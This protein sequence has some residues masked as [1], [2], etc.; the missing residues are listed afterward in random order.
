MKMDQSKMCRFSSILLVIAVILPAALSQSLP[1]VTVVSTTYQA[2]TGGSVTLQCTA[3]GNPGVTVIT[4]LKTVNSVESTITIDGSKYQQGTT[5]NPSLV[6]TSLATSDTATYVCRAT[7]SI[8][9]TDSQDIQL[10]VTGAPTVIIGQSAY[11]VNT[12]V[13]SVTLVCTVNNNGAALTGVS[14]TRNGATLTIDGTKYQNA[15]TGTP[16]LTITSPTNADDGTYVCS[17]SNSQGTTSSTPTTLTV[18]SNPPDVTIAQTAFGAQVSTTITL[19]CTVNSDTTVI[20]VFWQRDIGSGTETITV[21]GINFSGSTPTVPSLT[22]INADTTDSGSYQCF[23]T[24]AAG[25]SSSAIASVTIVSA[26]PTVTVAQSAYSI[27]TGTSVTLTCTV[28]SA[29]TVTSVFWQRTIGGNTVTLTIDNVN[30]SGSSPSTPSLTVIAADSGDVGSYTCFAVNNAGTGNSAAT[31][32]SVTGNAPTVTVGSSSYSTTTGTTFTLQCTVTSSLTI[33]NVFWQRTINGVTNS[34]T[35]DNVNYSGATTSSPSLTIISA[36]SGDT[37]TY[38]CFG[39]NTAGT[40]SATTQLT[41]TGAAPTVTV[42]STSYST[43]TGTTFTLQCTVTSSLT[44]NNVFWQRTFNGVTTTLTI[45]NVNY[46]GATTSSPSLTII[47]ADSGDTGTYTCFGSNAAGTSSATTQLTVTGTAPTVTVGSTAYSTTTGT[48]FTLQC[49]VTSSLTITNVFWQ[50]TINGV[51][52]TLTIDNV[53]YSG[54]STSSPSLTIISVDPT[55]TG[56]YTCFG[57]NAAGTSSATTQLTVTG[58]IPVVSVGQA[59]YSVTTGTTITLACTVSADPTHTTVFWRRDVGSGTESLTIDN[60]NYSGSQVNTPSL[61][62]I[63]TEI[64]DSGT[65]TCFATNAVGTGQSSTTLTVSGTIPTATINEATAT[66]LIASTIV[67]SCTVSGNPAVSSVFWQKTANS[68]TENVNIDDVKFSGSTT[69]F[70]SLIIFNAASSDSGDYQCFAVNDVG[71]GQSSTITLTVTGTVPT[72]TVTQSFYTATTGTSITLGCTVSNAN[73]AH[74]NVFWQRNVGTG[75]Q[76]ITIDN[77]NYSG[78]QVG[79]PSLTVINVDPTDSGTYSCFATN[80]VGTSTGS[81]TTLTVTGNLPVVT[82]AQTVYSVTTGTTVTLQCSVSANPTHTSVFWQFTP[83]NGGTTTLT[84]D[85]VNYAGS[86]VSSPSLVVFN[87]NSGDQGTYTCFATNQVGTGQSAQVSLSVTGSLPVV[88]VAQNAYSVT[89][90]QSITLGC[91]VSATPTHTNVFWQRIDNGVASTLNIDGVKYTGSTVNGPSLTINSASSNDATVYTCSATNAVGTGTSGQT[92]LSVTGNLPVVTV[93]Q[94]VYSVA[95]GQSVTLQCSVSANPTHTSVFWQFTPTNGGTTTLTIDNVNYA[96]SSVSSPSLVVFNANSGDQ[97]TY[98]C[99]ATNQVGTGQSAQVSLS[100]TGSLPVVLVDQAQYSVITG[101]TVTLGCTVTAT[102]GHTSVLWRRSLNGVETLITI[103]GTKYQ[104]ATVANPDLTITNAAAGDG[105]QYLCT[106]TNVVGTGTST[107]T[108]LIV[109]GNIPVVTVSQTVYSVTTGQAVT[110]QCSVSANPTHTSVF[111]QFT[112]TNGGTTT[113]TIDNVNYAGSSVSSPSLVVFNTNSGDQGTYTCFATNQVGTGQSAQVSLSVTGSLPVVTI[114]QNAYSVT[115]GQ[116]ITLGCTVSA[117]PTHTNVFW[118]RIDNGVS[119]T[120]TIDGSKYTGSTV[121]GPS[122]TINSASSNDA[123]VYTC[124]ATN[125]VGTGTSGQTS[126]SVTGNIPVVTVSQTVYSVTTGTT[127]TLQCSVSANPTHT[128]VFWQFTPTNGGTTTLTIDNVNYAGSSVSS[129]SLV[130]FNTNSGDQGTYTCFATNQV[131]T[132]QSAQV[133]LSVT[134][135]IPVVTV[136]QAQYSVITGQTVTLGCTVTATPGHTNVFWQRTLNGV[137]NT[138]TIDGNKYQGVTVANPDLTI[139]NAVAGDQAVYSCSATNIVGTGTSTTTTLTVTGNLPIVTIAQNTYSVTTGQS[140]TLGCTVSATPT[141]TNVFWQRIDNGV[142]TTLN[143]DGIKYSGSTVN[144]P[145]LTI[146]SANSNDAT[147][148]TCSATNAVGTGTSGQTTLSVTGNLPIVT[149]SQNTYSVTTGQSITLVCTVSATPTHTNVFWQRIDNGVATTLN[150]DGVKYSGSTVNGPSLTI[151]SANSN[152]ATVYTCSATNAVGTGTSGQTT[153]TVTGSIPVVTVDQAQNS[154]ITGQTVTLGCTVTATPGHTTVFWQRTLNG[155]TNSITI[156]GTKYQGATVAN[157]DLTITN[158]VAGDQAVY[159]CSATNIVGT[160]TSTTTTLTVTGSIPV[161]TVDQAQYSVITGQTVTLGCTVAATPGHTSVFW[162]RTLNGNTNTLTIDGT[163]YQGATLANPDLIITNAV[164]GDQAVYTC[165]ATNIVGTGTSTTTTLTVTGSLPIV[166]IAQNAYSVTTGQSITLG[167]TVSATPTHTNVFWQR[168]DNGVATTLT[169]D[170]TKYTGS[171]VNG[172]SLTIN[173]ASSNDATVYTCSAT[174]TVGTGTSGQTTLTVTGSIPVVTV[175]QAQY[176]VITG[177]TVTLG[178]TVAATPGH[179]SVFWQRTLNGNTNTLTIDGTK[180]QGATVANPDLII[181]NAVAGDQAVYTCSAT[182]IVGTG[183]STTTTLTVTGSLPIVTIAQNTYSVTTGQSITLG[184]TVSATP[185]H[186][187]VFW[188]RIDN[189]VATTLNIDGVKYSGS[190]VNGP[191]LTI[192]SANSNDATVYTCSATN[193]VGTGTSGQTTLTVTGSLPIVTI[194][195]NAYSV[196]TGQSITLGCTVS[197]TPTHTN[198]FWQRIDNGV[199]TTLTIDGSKYTGSTVNGPSLTIN[200]ASSNDATVYTCSATNAVGTGTSGQTALSV[201][202]SIPVVTVDQAQYSVITGQTVTLGCTVTATP[203]HNSVFWQRTLNGVTSTLTIDGNKYQ[204]ATVANPDL[205]I[206]NAVAGDQAVYTCSATNIVGT[207]TSTTTTLTVTGSLPI[208]TIAQNAYSVTTGQSITLVCTVSATPTH[209]NV[210]WQRIDNGVA[211]T[212][213]IDGVKYSGS[214]VNGPS[215][216][217]N[218]ASSNDATVYT[219]SA[220]NA[221][222]TGTS[223]QTTLT[224]TGSIPVVTVDQAQYSVITGQ[225]VTLGCTVTATPGHTSVFWQRTLNGVTNTLTIDGAKY[226]GATVA[227]P[228]LI[229]TNAVAGDQAVYTCSATNI[230]GT[231]TSTTTTLTVT[232]SLPIVTIAQNAYS[233]TTGQSIT[234]VCTVSATPTHTNVFWQR[235][236]NGVATT[237]TIDGSK[238]TGSTVNGPSLTINSASSNDAT[239]YTCSATNAVGTGTSGQTTLTVTGSIP[240]VT[241]DQAQYSVITGQTVTLGCTVAATPGHTTVFWQRTLNGVTST[242]NIDG[243]KYQGATVANPDLTITNSV[244]NDQAVYTCSATNIVGTGTSTTTTLTVTGSL[245]IVTI[246]QNAYSVTTGQSITLGCTVS[247]TPTHTN[248][249][250]QRIDNGVATTLTIDGSKYTGSTVNGPSLTINSANSNDATVYTCSATNAVGTGTSGQTALSVTGSIPVVTVDQAQYSVITGQTVTLGCTVAATP[251][252]TSAF[253][254]RTLNG[255][256]STLTIDGNKYQGSTVANPDLTITNAVASDLAVYTC[257]ATNIVGTGTSTTTTLTVTGSIPVVTVDQAQ[258]SVITGQTVTLG[259]TVTATPVHTSVFWRKTLNGVTSSVTVDGNKYQGATVANPDLII[260]NAVA[261]DQAVYTCSATN[262]VGTGTSTTTTLTVTGSLPIVTIAQNTYSVTTGQSITL[263][264]TVSATPTHTNVFWQRIDN[265]VATTLTIDGSKYT[266]STVNGPSLTINSAS[267]N[268]ATVYTCSATNAVGTGTSGQTTLSV[269]GNVPVVTVDQA[270]YSVIT[271]QTVTLGCTVTATPGHTSVLWR[272]LLNG[273]TSN[274]VI[275]NSKYQGATVANPDLTITNAVAGDQAVYT[276]SATNIVGT[277]TS[278]TTTLTVTGNLPIVTI[279]Q[280]TYSVT[281]G[282]S[283]TLGCSV[284]ATPTHTNVFWQRIDNGVATTLTIDGSKYTGSTVNGPSLTIN[285]ANSNDATVYTCSATNAVGTGTSGQTTLAVTGSIPVVTVDQAQYSVITGQTVTLGCTVTAT[286]GH[287]SVFWQRT[288]N[289]VTS[290]LSIDGTKYQ[291][292]TVANPDLTIT[293]AVAGDQAVYTCSATNIVGTG[294][295]TTTTLTVTGSLPI[296]TVAQNAYSVVTGQTI[297]LGCTVSATPTHTNVFWQRIDNGVATTLTI[298]GTKY[299]GSTVNNP[300]LT[301]F[302]SAANDATVYT[303]SATNAVGTGTSGQT[304]LAVTGSIPVVTIAQPAYSVITG[305]TVVLQCIVSADPTH[306]QVFWQRTVNGNT[307]NVAIDGNK[308]QGSVPNT[309]SLTITN[310]ASS[311]QATYTCSATNAVGTGT[312]TS[313]TLTVTGSIPVVTVAQSS[314]SV[315]TGSTATLECTVSADPTHTTVFWQRIVNGVSTNIVID[316]NN[317]AG[318]SV[319]SPSLQV[320]NANSGDEG[321]YICFATNIV[322]T[323]QSAQTTLTVTGNLPVVVIAQNAYSVITGQSITLG[324][325]VTATPSHTNVY[326]QRIDNGVASTL[327]IDGTKYTGSTVNGPSLTI[328]NAENNDQTTY[329]CSAT[330]AVGT[331]T[332]GQTTL[333]VTGNVPVVN[334]MQNQYNV[335]TGTTATLECVVSADPAHFSVYWQ[336]VQNGITE[337]IQIDGVNYGGSTVSDPS[338]VVFNANTADQGV[339]ICFATNIVGTGQSAQ[340]VLSV[341]GSLPVVVIAQNAYSVTTGQSITLGCTVT[342]T[343][344][345]TNVYWQRIDNGVASTLTIDGSKYT[346]STVNGPSLTINNA[347][348][349]DQ[350]TYTC[351]ATNAVGTGTSGQTTLTVTG[352]PPVPTI[353]QNAYSV[354]TGQ[355]ITLECTVQSDPAHTTVFWQRFVNGQAQSITIDGTKYLGATVNSASLVINNAVSADQGVYI[356]FAT[357]IV[358]TGQSGQTVLSVTGS[359]PVVTI[360]QPSYSAITGQ[361]VTLECTVSANPTHSQVFW[362]RIDNGVATTINLNN[363]NKYSGSTVNSPSLTIL[364]VASNDQALYTCSATNVVGTGTS[365]QTTLTVTGSIPVVTIQQPTYSV[366]TGQSVTLTCVVT[367]TPQ[368]TTVFWQRVVNGQS[369]SITIDNSKYSG[370]TVSSPSITISNAEAA[371][372]G[373]YI[374]FATNIV[375]TGQSSQ[376]TLT[377][378]GT[379][380][381]VTIAQASYSVIT[382]QSITLGCTVSADPLHTQVYWQRVINGVSNV[383]TIDGNKYAGSTVNSPDLVIFNAASGDIATYT[384]S[385]VNAV[386]TGTSAT[387]TLTVT[388]SPPTVTI[389]QQSYTITIGTTVTIECTVSS[390]PTHTSVFWQRVI[391]GQTESI[392]IDGTNFGGSTVGSASLI[393]FNADQ[394]DEGTYICFATNVVGTGQSSPTALVVTGSIPVVTVQQTQ[395]SIVTGNDVT[396]QCT[397]TADPAHTSV[398]WERTIGGVTTQL[399]IDNVNYAGSQVNNPSLTVLSATTADS[400]VYVCKASNVVGTGQSSSVQLSV[401]GNVPSVV[402]PQPSYSVLTGSS[403]TLVCTVSGSPTHT[404]VQWLRVVNGVNQAVNIG[405][406]GKYAGSTVSVPSL[407]INGAQ[408]SDQGQYICTA[409]NVV[410]T[411][412]SSVTT[413]SV[414]GSLPVVTVAQANYNVI[415]GGTITLVCTINAS[416]AATTM[417]WRRLVG[418]ASEPINIDNSKYTGGAINNPSLTITNAQNSDEGF[419]ICQATNVVGTG[420]STNTYLDV[421]GTIPV[422]TISQNSY[423][424]L[425]GSSV[426]IDCTVSA[427][428]THTSVEW[429]KIT[430]TGGNTVTTPIVI[431]NINFSGGSVNSPDLTVITAEDSDEAF[432]VCT[433][434]NSVGLGTSNQAFLSVDGGPPTVQVPQTS[435]SIITGGTITLQ[436]NVFGNPAVT[437]VS[438]TRSI[439]NGPFLTINIDGTS[440]SGS[441]VNNPSLTVINADS[442]DLGVY[443]C[444]ATNSIGTA[445]S[446]DV[447]LSV[448]GDPPTVTVS[449]TSYNVIT[450]SDITIQ[451]SVTA[452]PAASTVFWEKTVNG[453]TNRLTI[454]QVAYGG[455]TTSS[456]SLIVYSAQADDSGVYVC[457]ASN[458]VGTGQSDQVTISVTGAAPVVTIAQ[459]SYT[460]TTGTTATLVCTVVATPQASVVRWKK[461][462]NGVTTTITINNAKYSGGSVTSPTLVISSAENSDVGFYVCEATNAVGT[463]TSS[464]TYLEITGDLPI[465]QVLQPFYTVTKGQSVTLECTVSGT[466]VATSVSWERTSAGVTTVV[467]IDNNQYQGSTANSP[468]LVISAADSID[469]GTYV[470]TATN[471]VGTRRS[472]STS[473]TVTG[474]IPTVAIPDPSYTVVTGFSVTIPCTVSADPPAS[475]VTWSRQDTINDT[476]T[477]LT[478]DNTNYSGGST[479]TPSLTINNAADSDQGFYICSAANSIGTGTSGQSYLTVTG[480]PPT[481]TIPSNAY[482]VLTGNSIQIPCNVVASP[483]ATVVTWSKIVSTGGTDVTSTITIDGS[484]YQGSNIGNPSLRINN[485]NNDDQ[486]SYVCSATNSVGSADSIRTFLTVSGSIPQVTLAAAFTT[487][488]GT[489]VTLDCT[490]SASP[491]AHSIYWEFIRNGVTTTL[492]IDG[493]KFVGSAV[494]NPSLTINSATAD[495]EG[496]YIC[497]AVNSVGLGKSSQAYL[498]V[499]GNVPSVVISQ[500]SY[501]AVIGESVTIDCDY[502]STPDATSIYWNKIV[503]QQT[504]RITVTQTNEYSGATLSN[505]SLTISNTDRDDQAFYRCI[506]TNDVGE[507]QSGQVYLYITGNLPTVTVPQSSYSVSLEDQVTITCVVTA[508]PA[509]TSVSWEY[510]NSAGNTMPVDFTNSRFSGGT[511]A[512]PSLTI[513]SAVLGDQGSYKCKAS[514][515]VGEG[516]S[517]ETYLYVTGTRPIVRVTVSAYTVDIGGQAILACV[518]ESNPPATTVTWN[519]IVDGASTDISTTASKY[520]GATVSSP[521]LVINNLALSDQGSYRCNARNSVGVGSSGLTSLIVAYA[522]RN[523]VVDPAAVTRRE[524]ESFTSECSTDANP[525]ASYQWIKD[526]T[527]QIVSN[528]KI[529]Q[530]SNIDRGHAGT[531][532][533]TATNT[534]GSDTAKLSVDVQYKPISTVTVEEATVTLSLNA[535]KNLECN[536]VANPAVQTYRWLKDGTD[537]ANADS[538]VY[539]VTI[540]DTT[541]YGVY[542]CYATNVIGQSSAIAFTVQSGD[543]VTTTAAPTDVG[544]TTGVIIAIVI[545]AVVFLLIVIIAVCCC[546]TH[547]VCR[548]DEPYETKRIIVE[549]PAMVREPTFVMPRHEVLALQEESFYRVPSGTAYR[550]LPQI[551]DTYYESEGLKADRRSYTASSIH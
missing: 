303:C 11:N 369:Q 447:T 414:T 334:I 487:V 431:D 111:W 128:S 490:V 545:A 331:G 349:N 234:L 285:S 531:Y 153:L 380:P 315:I 365:T 256:T 51:T 504:T 433:A 528:E 484:K 144:G 163:K 245:P 304:T 182:N 520:D 226:Q 241:V 193:A 57:A 456:P 79:T 209:T 259:C 409:S 142:A 444:S 260:T 54:V 140:I 227:N 86:S 231:G 149:I 9:F 39:S 388:G 290:T 462:A 184:C 123:T 110:L 65:Y 20:S 342:A 40:S 232:G 108:E 503:N 48:T 343:P 56:T 223:G 425:V 521:S 280:N 165:S 18:T 129:P 505:P 146:N 515:S 339:Y 525:A 89:T 167:C 367:A 212:L 416:P 284:S 291:G 222:G 102:P 25:T 229:I 215:L 242:L 314:Y 378:T 120:L 282:Q 99:F 469:T 364:N 43:T 243:A 113:L 206:T 188:Q 332:S 109:T 330:N 80:A 307:N 208:V 93:S 357:N 198:V 13:N 207:G 318:S 135:S 4:W 532:T 397:V 413:L 466:P 1:S 154:V 118:Q 75:T 46:S 551:S 308:F 549:K 27:T 340:T 461:T 442:T 22:I 230:V 341:T 362:Q 275:D 170:G 519:K 77:V 467:T 283:I 451:C 263:G 41:V 191:S 541:S 159:T 235:I 68:I 104:G 360:A 440:F 387:T 190:T 166:T 200:S 533:C 124:S 189:G 101:Q 354:I 240:V 197:A 8:G 134:G 67:L 516:E 508:T 228:D 422:V 453:V 81:T 329:T 452:I 293:N 176:S 382:G 345:H 225:T 395:Y 257:S 233:V 217:I 115:T 312:S 455:S 536:T 221:V 542:T 82:V 271:G 53:N 261:G 131:G 488:L 540:T 92:S 244:A 138:L 344:S 177:Q 468:S 199:A 127:V 84:I 529:L 181:T 501:T 506:V 449:Q 327:T 370:A 248:V 530:I 474:D 203:G 299:S 71:T 294:T 408:S 15:N 179:T 348:A 326:W 479:S 460:V 410:G 371:D 384:C 267:S 480:D 320:F 5:S 394:A 486:A 498:T 518:V 355:S 437:S 419:Y 42:G 465:V 405:T 391:N 286:P 155:N 512:S 543:V 423:N 441:A 454:D 434:T 249:F 253:W 306:T 35:I 485:A 390:T 443:R 338:L 429:R 277:G 537:I 522:P 524:Q 62:V 216:T 436:C 152:D 496:N 50:R 141:H 201:T 133:S 125:A 147:V 95:T 236:D 44:I 2:N 19:G 396:I 459:A 352:S 266:G 430:N 36:D 323:G 97:G 324:C 435:Y 122:L 473:L 411:G 150:I 168:I 295:S 302:S 183:T 112:P 477:V 117:T 399:N 157:P 538:L 126:L 494:N 12:G 204:G 137:T 421:T 289:G 514:N 305:Q 389:A 28:S 420:E 481:V 264:C 202:G 337:N 116:S 10:T 417:A 406:S 185:T 262:I 7:N 186:T 251:G 278:T 180:Y 220:T 376:T 517:S 187:N 70:P 548:T 351:S 143:L 158:A 94:T 476:P 398:F 274:V 292:A 500:P 539:Q 224:V 279:A 471:T 49:T 446:S 47:S 356:C 472:T 60:V 88:T 363:V 368:H 457:K 162:Q 297:T 195:Q 145:S 192:N 164:A 114:A 448:T 194:A 38:T 403:V 359:I 445:Q 386:G 270:Q 393:V 281:T 335:V 76:S 336:R 379:L 178:C 26:V 509:A 296:V 269:T 373:V 64:A 358:G 547:G 255:V 16:S 3:S 546:V 14:W 218:S 377:V 272:K 45:D 246:A 493:T 151:N 325:T 381:V 32:L 210:F 550:Y 130:V 31:T 175:D 502:S 172:P 310:A 213:N 464:Q 61:T 439:N 513:A 489:S 33:T 98:T 30:Y 78:S 328:N 171:T 254:Q 252:H 495:D 404:S 139:T 24:N 85:N 483:P 90:G 66:G 438:W 544:L 205:I 400:G 311:D 21:D 219:C 374:C 450:G 475:S 301:I 412:Q 83:T 535:Q 238:Y 287:T 491:Q 321:V 91:T 173:S 105:A 96:G 366:I 313:T 415:T 319:N 482:S 511:V 247:A 288:L 237:L 160:G 73:P 58:S 239:V 499:T 402:V 534:Q 132:G 418:G 107:V 174:N 211:S 361:S 37:G 148:Y 350:T 103:D 322:G 100:V 309:P 121:N 317:Y 300:S 526:S 265:G 497:N 59:S 156:D 372:G 161:V 6:I 29:T 458:A 250:W 316:G 426:T 23:A 392:T 276:C 427:V 507:G 273:V 385:A 432:Y 74:T 470:C 407:T 527:S 196:T 55:D 87:T 298:D 428:P 52:N 169:I 214:T 106:A 383:I 72:T 347:A 492:T 346:G 69:N 353:T 333:T 34:L 63:S 268:D 258:Y 463:G 401:T 17:A 119:T 523:T 136:D 375:G 510:T 424:V 478:I